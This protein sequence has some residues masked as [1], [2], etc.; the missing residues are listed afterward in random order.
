MAEALARDRYEEHGV[1]PVRIGNAPKRAIPFKTDVPF[2]KINAILIAPNGSEQK[3]EFLCDG[4]QA[5]VHGIHPDTHAP[6]RWGGGELSDVKRD[7]LPAID[8]A[9]AQEL[10]NDIIELLVVEH[11]YRRK[12]E[13][14]KPRMVMLVAPTGPASTI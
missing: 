14:H 8:A 7:D 13:K 12:E 6:Y 10:V 4:Q 3:I 2:P 5:V 9:A 1:F 11:G